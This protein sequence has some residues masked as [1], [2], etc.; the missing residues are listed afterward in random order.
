MGIAGNEWG[1]QVGTLPKGARDKISDVPGVT[2][3]HC[4]LADGV[5]QTGVTALLPHQG[6]IFH[7]KVLA[8]SYVIN[9]FGKT[10]G[11]VQI[12]ELGTLETPIALTNTL[13]VGLVYDAMVEYMVGRCAQ[14]GTALRSVNPVVAECNDGGLND[15]A[16]RAV[17]QEHVFAAIENARADFEEGD[18]GAGKGMVC[19]GLKGGIGSASRIVE[20]DGARYTLGVLALAN[21]GRLEDL[22]IG[23]KSVGAKIAAH[24]ESAPEQ[25]Q[26]KGSCIV[27]M[28][29]DLPLCARQLERVVKRASV[30]LARLGSY[31]GHG[32]GEVFLG[33]ST[34]NRVP[35]ESARAVLPCTVLHEGRIDAV[36]RAMGEATEEAVL[37]AMLCADTVTGFDGSTKYT[38]RN[39]ASQIY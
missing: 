4:T 23:G 16:R 37:R 3:G 19:H 1:F 17:R 30:G 22:C 9:G 38:I 32:S 35:H 14:S 8:A 27:V 6:D 24:L 10:T 15:I 29:T 7:E 18:V 26:D 25:Q 21:H 39:F 31:I 12:D 5:V 33:F 36:F 11:L 28:A 34:T 13:N 2:V 20:L